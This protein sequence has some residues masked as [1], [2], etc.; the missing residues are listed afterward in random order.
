MDAS[1]IEAKQC[2][3]NK[4]KNSVSTQVPEAKWNV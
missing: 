4:D 3:L 1:V 2:C